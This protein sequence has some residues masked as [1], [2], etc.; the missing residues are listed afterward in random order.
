MVGIVEKVAPH[1]TGWTVDN[2]V[3]FELDTRFGF[4]IYYPCKFDKHDFSE[5]Q[6]SYLHRKINI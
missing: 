4:G 3:G 6:F 5:L 2:I 1:L